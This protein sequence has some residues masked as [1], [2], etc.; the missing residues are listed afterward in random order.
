MNIYIEEVVMGLL[1]LAI[2]LVV[3]ALVID[4]V[5]SYRSFDAKVA[6]AQKRM[7][8]RRRDFSARVTCVP[9]ITRQDTTTVNVR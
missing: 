6:C 2:A 5:Q 3:G 8:P 7:E 9:A 4:G 1:L